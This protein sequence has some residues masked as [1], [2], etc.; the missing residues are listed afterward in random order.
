MSRILIP[1]H[2]NIGPA[3]QVGAPHTHRKNE[4]YFGQ[5]WTLTHRKTTRGWEAASPTTGH[6]NKG[7]SSRCPS[8]PPLT[9]VAA[10]GRDRK[11]VGG[12]AQIFHISVF[13]HPFGRMR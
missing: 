7:V 8:A 13:S 5:I 12:T 4:H 2:N 11:S 3:N 10:P 6:G 1:C 9:A